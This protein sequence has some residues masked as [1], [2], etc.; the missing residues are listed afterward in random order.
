[1]A[2]QRHPP[3]EPM[4]REAVRSPPRG[5]RTAHPVFGFDLTNPQF[6]FQWGLPVIGVIFSAVM[7]SGIGF[8]T[9]LRAL[10]VEGQLKKGQERTD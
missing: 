9:S 6:C 5:L 8:R 7:I 4:S 3:G 10:I 1:M 2:Q